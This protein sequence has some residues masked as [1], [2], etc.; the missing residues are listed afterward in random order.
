MLPVA[1]GRAGSWGLPGDDDSKEVMRIFLDVGRRRRVGRREAS[2]RRAASVTGW[3]HRRRRDSDH[4]EVPLYFV[5]VPLR[6]H[7]VCAD[8]INYKITRKRRARRAAAV[9]IRRIQRTGKRTDG[10]EEMNRTRLVRIIEP[11]K[12]LNSIGVGQRRAEEEECQKKKER[13]SWD[14]Y[15]RKD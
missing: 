5:K 1:A 2:G 7:C 10:R 12:A 4:F 15:R 13:K 11:T 8:S 3:R 9:S 14:R 6:F